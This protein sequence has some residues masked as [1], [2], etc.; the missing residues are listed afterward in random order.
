[1]GKVRKTSYIEIRKRKRIVQEKPTLGQKALIIFKRE[2][3]QASFQQ[4]AD[5]C[6]LSVYGV[7]GICQKKEE[8]RF[9]LA[10]GANPNRKT[11]KVN[12]QFPQI[13]EQ[14]LK[15]LKMAREKRIPVR[16]VFL[17]NV[18]TFVASTLAIADFRCSWGWYDKF[19]GRHNVNLKQLHGEE[20]STDLIALE[21]WLTVDLPALLEL[22]HP[23][24]IWNCDETGIWWRNAGT[25]SL[26]FGNKQDK[27]IKIAK[28][29]ITVHISVSGGGRKLPL[30]IINTS[31]QPRSF[32]RNAVFNI[33]S[34]DYGFNYS[35][36]KTAW[37][38]TVIF[39][40]YLDWLNALMVKEERHILLLVDNFS[41][42][43]V[44]SRP[45]IE[46]R[47]L[48]PNCTAIA[49]PCDAGIIKCLKDEYKKFLY[50]RVFTNMQHV[51]NVESFVKGLTIF[52]A[53]D[54]L[55]EAWKLVK[56]STIVNCFHKCKIVDEL[57]MDVPVEEP[58]E[59]ELIQISQFAEN[60]VGFDDDVS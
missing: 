39:E 53:V 54:W 35:Y 15:F 38:T 19:C 7:I 60:V 55:V 59:T 52:D 8:I 36:N 31:A 4:I 11:T 5:E 43:N 47:F 45:N 17:M 12:L 56:P 44:A 25:K 34:D 24:N 50:K 1:M 29:R 48:P 22:I 58:S 41:G 3:Q 42:H 16:P 33:N 13:D 21:Q 20:S 27:G 9:A 49:Q 2:V 14:C 23:E 10:N 18:A 46:L 40:E 28:D 32:E 30:W 26:V 51:S 57:W 6:G 37:M